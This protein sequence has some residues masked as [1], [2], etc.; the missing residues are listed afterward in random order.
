MRNSGHT[1]VI[2]EYL[3]HTLTIYELTA[4]KAGSK[5]SEGTNGKY[6]HKIYLKR[7]MELKLIHVLHFL[8]QSNLVLL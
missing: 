6:N 4:E 2:G 7:V 1:G 8:E 3:Q 5:N